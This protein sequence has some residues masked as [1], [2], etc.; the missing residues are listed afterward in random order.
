MHHNEEEPECKQ[1]KIKLIEL[2]AHYKSV[3]SEVINT[4]KISKTE[5][6]NLEEVIIL[7]QTFEHTVK[8]LLEPELL[9]SDL[10]DKFSI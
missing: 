6:D 3:I 2:I 7:K 4:N 9:V 10:G 1:E 8:N 5:I